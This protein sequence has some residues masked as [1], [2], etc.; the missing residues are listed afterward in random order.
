MSTR[1]LTLYNYHEVAFR[2]N[3]IYDRTEL[4]NQQRKCDIDHNK[5]ENTWELKLSKSIK[6][7][8]TLKQHEH[9]TL[10]QDDKT[11]QGPNL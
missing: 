11:P 1:T 4:E 8:Q 7:A 6:R 10:S 9:C 2:S 3:K 5:G